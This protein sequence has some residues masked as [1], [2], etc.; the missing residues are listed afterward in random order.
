MAFLDTPG[1]TYDWRTNI[2]LAGM[3]SMDTSQYDVE[4]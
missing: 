1:A 3:V 2:S 4:Q